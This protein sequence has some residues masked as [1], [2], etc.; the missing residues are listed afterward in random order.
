MNSGKA[1]KGFFKTIVDDISMFLNDLFAGHFIKQVKKDLREIQEFYLE[2]ERIERLDKM[3]WLRRSVYSMFWL[4]QTVFY[5]LT[6]FRRLFLF[7]ALILLIAAPG[8]NDGNVNNGF[9]LSGLIFFFILLLELKDKT[10]AK[11]ELQAGRSVQKALSP[12]THPEIPGWDIWLYTKS[13]NDVGGDLLDYF[14]INTKRHGIAVGDLAGKG[15]PAALHMAKLQ[16]I[17]R[18]IVPDFTSLAKMCTKLNQIF[19]RDRLPNSFA[20]LVYLELE[21]DNNQV[22]L[23]NAGHLP[24]II[25]HNKSIS[26]MDKGAP[27]LGLMPKTTYKERQLQM[28]TGDLLVVY[29]DG[30]SEAMNEQKAFFG[31]KRL[32]NILVEDCENSA[33]QIGDMLLKKL[34]SYCG[35]EPTADDI[36]VAII[37]KT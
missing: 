33:E 16:A 22:K 20:S 26:E 24:P 3:N 11:N 13:A 9:V 17:M 34:D 36:S 37:K 4:I 28:E 19:H 6:S 8:S 27:A 35:D 2:E 5:E 21:T 7:L 30:I 29:S 25:I 14:T 15:L 23:V 12:D 31:E 10:I 18:A 32:Y 1:K